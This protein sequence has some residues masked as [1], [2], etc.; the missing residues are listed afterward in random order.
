MI[1]ET[2]WSVL[3]TKLAGVSRNEIDEATDNRENDTD[4]ELGACSQMGT[5]PDR[6]DRRPEDEG[7]T[8]TEE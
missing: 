8:K 3:R 2:P 5:V 1:G 7:A 6:E 4:P